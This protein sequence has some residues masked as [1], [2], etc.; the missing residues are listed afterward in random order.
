MEKENGTTTKQTNKQY[1]YSA[2]GP[3]KAEMRRRRG[4]RRHINI[5]FRGEEKQRRKGGRY[6]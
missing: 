3:W 5:S 6:V 4:K 1:G 2:N